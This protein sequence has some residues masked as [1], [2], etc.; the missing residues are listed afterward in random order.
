MNTME[1]RDME[2]ASKKTGPAAASEESD[3]RLA[4]PLLEAAEK[5]GVG[6]AAAYEAAHRGDI[7]T[8]RVGKRFLVPVAAFNRLLGI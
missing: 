8:I 3:N 6:K 7:P 5:L 4:I 2:H 1:S